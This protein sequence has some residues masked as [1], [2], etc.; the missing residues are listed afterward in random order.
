MIGMVGPGRDSDHPRPA[1]DALVAARG[2]AHPESVRGR[3]GDP[4]QGRPGIPEH[5]SHG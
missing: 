1:L 4:G 2:V 3:A 5:D